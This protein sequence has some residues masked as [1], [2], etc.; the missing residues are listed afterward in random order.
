MPMSRSSVPAQPHSP[1]RLRRK[2]EAVDRELARRSRL[3]PW[4]SRDPLGMLIG[5][6]LSQHTS[7]TNSDRAYAQL[8]RR[9]PTWESVRA[10]GTP[11]IAAAIRPAGLA[12][13]KA[14]RIHAVL[15]RLARERGRL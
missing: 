6:I 7:D 13:L 8:R 12:A 5:T 11:Q 4:R 10:A 2:A 14:P 3:R 1:S 9:L 15:R